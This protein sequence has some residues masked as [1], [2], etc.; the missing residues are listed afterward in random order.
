MMPHAAHPRTSPLLPAPL[1]TRTACQSPSLK[2]RQPPHLCTACACCRYAGWGPGQ[3]ESECKRGVWF[4]A[5][6]SADM[7]LA[8]E[9]KGG[10]MW[11]AILRLMG[12]DY[13]RLS[14][15]VVEAEQAARGDS[16][17]QPGE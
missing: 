4:P 10:D 16:S 7:V 12:G 9:H 1:A 2:L 15:S 5:A 17:L 3:L 11:H 14:S 6:A 8:G 13:A